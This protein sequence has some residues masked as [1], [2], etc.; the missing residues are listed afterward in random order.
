MPIIPKFYFKDNLIK[1]WI[2]EDRL[3]RAWSILSHAFWDDWIEKHER[4]FEMYRWWKKS[5]ERL[6]NQHPIYGWL[7]WVTFEWSCYIV[8]V[9]EAL[10]FFSKEKSIKEMIERRWKCKSSSIWNNISNES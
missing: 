5:M 10:A 6:L 7:S 8:A 4:G 2:D 1:I 9:W 3:S